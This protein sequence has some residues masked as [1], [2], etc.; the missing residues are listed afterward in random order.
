MTNAQ[1]VICRQRMIIEERLYSEKKIL[2][3]YCTLN[4][5]NFQYFL[6]QETRYSV[7]FFIKYK[8]ELLLRNIFSYLKCIHSISKMFQNLL[9]NTFIFKEKVL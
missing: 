4:S 3:R 8:K 5:T 2:T 1:N 9:L 6:S 7:F